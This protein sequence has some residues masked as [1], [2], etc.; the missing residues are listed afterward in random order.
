[1]IISGG[2]VQDA[3]ALFSQGIICYNYV[4][5]KRVTFITSWMNR[6]SEL[7]GDKMKKRDKS[8]EISVDQYPADGS[9]VCI[10]S[11]SGSTDRCGND[12]GGRGAS[13]GSRGCHIG[14]YSQCQ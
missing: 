9:I 11:D 6:V 1:M 13:G 7:L 2:E 8:K 14:R 10:Q 4:N 5:G 3:F 12:P